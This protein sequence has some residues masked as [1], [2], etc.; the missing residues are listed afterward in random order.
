MSCLNKLLLPYHETKIQ[1]CLLDI[2]ETWCY[3]ILALS[4]DILCIHV[5]HS[6]SIYSNRKYICTTTTTTTNIKITCQEVLFCY[7]SSKLI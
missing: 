5:H 6:D 4:G 2:G 7:V 1:K 3:K